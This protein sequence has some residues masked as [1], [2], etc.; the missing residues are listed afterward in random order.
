MAAHLSHN[1]INAHNFEKSNRAHP[2]VSTDP[3][4][5]VPKNTSNA[6][7]GTLLKLERQTD[8]SLYT[9]PPNISLSRLMYQ[10]QTSSGSLVPVSACIIW[11]YVARAYPN[12]SGYP[13][14]AWA[15]GTSGSN[16]ECAPSNIKNLWHHFQAPYQLALNGYVVVA[17]DYAGLGVGADDNG[18]QIVF[19][20]L[21]GCAQAGDIA[22]SI[23]AARS[24]FSELSKEFV[25]IG[26]SLGG[27]GAWAFAER[28]ATRPMAGYL[29]TIA[30]SPVM[31]LLSLPQDNAIFPMLILLLIP[32]LVA[33]YTDFKA[34][35]ILTPAGMQCL[36]TYRMLQGCNNVLFQAATV[37]NMLKPGW[38]HNIHF[39][40]YQELAA[41]GGREISGPLLVVQGADDP[42]VSAQSVTDGVNETLKVFPSAQIEYH[43]LP[44]VT[45]ASA[46]YAG[47][48]LYMDWIAARFKGESAEAGYRSHVAQPIRPSG[49]QQIEANWIIQEQTEPWQAA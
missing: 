8:T 23:Q 42:V 12:I 40:K 29:G 10:S 46:M 43:I 20:Y 31:R 41:N 34:E 25:I 19:E 45:H 11:P 2:S 3:F 14:V 27:G 5:T 26:S 16:A 13:T 15:H 18:K 4:Y 21:T 39:Q 47:Q 22:F 7:P 30:L 6:P 1:I 48:Q 49:A 36:E 37:P 9:L 33:K 28:M 32:S 17:T 44:H 24:A 35:A 38:Q